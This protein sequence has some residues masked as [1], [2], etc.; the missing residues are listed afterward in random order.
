MFTFFHQEAHSVERAALEA[1]LQHRRDRLER[2]SREQVCVLRHVHESRL[3]EL[4]RAVPAVVGRDGGD[5]GDRPRSGDAGLSKLP[6]PATITTTP[7]PTGVT[8]A[9]VE[10]AY[11]ASD[12]TTAEASGSS[13]AENDATKTGKPWT[14]RNNSN[15]GKGAA[16]VVDIRT[17][18]PS[19][20]VRAVSA[21]TAAAALAAV[22]IGSSRVYKALV[23]LRSELGRHLAA[24]AH[25]LDGGRHL[26]EA[27][28][29]MREIEKLEALDKLE[30]EVSA[31]RTTYTLEGALHISKS[32][33]A[34]NCT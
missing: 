32:L 15:E 5:G 13:R 19:G 6:P 16:D 10:S 21:T 11:Q 22:T 20:A 29:V 25:V 9:V 30:A 17:Q 26:Q 1:D 2:S 14:D 28:R 18:A 8:A 7:T 31:T 33:S 12:V 4:C 23:E 27:T 34:C 3:A 24:V